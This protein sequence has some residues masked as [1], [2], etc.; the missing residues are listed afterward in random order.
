MPYASWIEWESLGGEVDIINSQ[1]L[2]I[3]EILPEGTE[4]IRLFR[5]NFYNIKG[6]INGKFRHFDELKVLNEEHTPLGSFIEPK[7][8]KIQDPTV[9]YEIK[10]IIGGSYHTTDFEFEYEFSPY[11]IRRE[12]ENSNETAWVTDWFLNGPHN[13]VF[14]ASTEYNLVENYKKSL[15]IPETY[16]NFP[17]NIIK[18]L[19]DDLTDFEGGKKGSVLSF[20]YSLIEFENENGEENYFIIHDVPKDIGPNWSN[21]LGIEYREKWGIPDLEERKKISE[22][23]SFIFGRQLLNIGYSKF[24]KYGNFV[25]DFAVDPILPNS[26]N[27]KRVC[28]LPDKPP[29]KINPF[30]SGYLEPIFKQLIPSYLKLSDDLNMNQVLWRYWLSIALNFDTSLLLLATSI[31]LLSNS[32]YKSQNSKSKGI[33]LEKKDFDKLLRC[34]FKLI[35]KKLKGQKYKER[36]LRRMKG[37]FQMGAN[38]KV[39]NFFDEINLNI[40]KIEKKAIKDRNIPAHGSLL[41]LERSKKIFKSEEAYR[42]LFNRT[43]LKI[44]GFNGKYID[45]YTLNYPERDID[46]PIKPDKE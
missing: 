41:D 23:V 38:E 27:I 44:L 18:N 19:H 46:E 9:T 37:T 22:L 28:G 42:T 34:E 31:E 32:W 2:V 11:S 8:L 21:K 24:D 6:I 16:K 20:N 5:D 12:F 25:E 39:N 33:Y 35:E 4:K 13:H 26:I 29:I 40:D 10:S 3:S 1:D 7:C 36:I 43:V 14:S 15:H 30:K 45:Y 17:D